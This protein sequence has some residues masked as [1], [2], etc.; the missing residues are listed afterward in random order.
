MPK[1]HSRERLY[2]EKQA[3]LAKA[4]ATRFAVVLGISVHQL[5]NNVHSACQQRAPHP[6]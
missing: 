3:S 2:K 1:F 6:E 5:G 4:L